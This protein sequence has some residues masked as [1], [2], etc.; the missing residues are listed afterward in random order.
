MTHA[1]WLAEAERRF[2]ADVM[3]WRFVCPVCKHVA[4]T[5]D[6]KEAGAPVEAVGFSCIG[7]WSGIKRDALG[8]NADKVKRGE[9]PPAEGDGPCNYAGGGLLQLNPVVV[10]FPDGSKGKAFAFAEAMEEA[11]QQ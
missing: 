4:S 3:A 5:R 11:R 10:E 6:Y 8:L 7:R 2:G 9:L 1:E